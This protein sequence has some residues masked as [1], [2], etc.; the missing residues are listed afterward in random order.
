L[1]PTLLLGQAQFFKETTPDGKKKTVPGPARL[2]VLRQGG[3]QWQREVLE[4]S[5]SNVFH[6]AI[7]WTEPGDSPAIP[8]ILTIGA[9]AAAVKLWHWTGD[10]WQGRLLWKTSFGGKQDRLRDF[11]IGDVDGDGDD[12]IVI[13]THDQGVVVVLTRE[14]EEWKAQELDR[15]PDIWVHEVELGDLDG[16][17]KVEIYATPSQPNRFDGTPQPGTVAVYRHSATGFERQSVEDFPRQHPKEILVADLGGD[18]RP[19][20]LAAVEAD[21]GKDAGRDPAANEVVIKQYHWEDGQYVGQAM[22]R[23]PDGLCRFLNA[24]DVDGDGKADLI[25]ST[26]KKGLWLVRTTEDPWQTE[27]IDADSGGFEHATVLAD[28]DGDGTQ[29]IYV[30]ADKQQQ[31]RRYR[32]TGQEWDRTTLYQ[33]EPDKITFCIS[34]GEL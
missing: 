8:G 10:G 19:L 33:M 27:L 22:C 34:V 13:G 17:G 6:K 25:A 24:G 20:L 32:W 29:E 14:G 12:D 18:G 26:H 15:K 28:L 1:R 16:D 11:E 7:V 21:L 30:V 23:L 9:N 4:D 5:E 31:A 2:V 3:D